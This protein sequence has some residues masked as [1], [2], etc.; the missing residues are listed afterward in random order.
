MTD[1]ISAQHSR[2]VG[3]VLFDGFEL[4]DAFGPVEI[5]SVLPKHF[6]L[7]F[8]STNARTV[9]SSQGV[10]VIADTTIA[11]AEPVD[12]LIVPGGIG[13]ERLVAD[14]RAL[15]ALRALAETAEIMASVC[16]GTAALAIAGILDGRAATSN[17]KAFDWVRSFGPNV[18]WKPRARWVTDAK[19]WTASGVAAGM[20]MTAALIRHLH[21]DET[22]Q[23]ATE[24]I[25]LEVRTD[26]HDDPFA[27]VSPQM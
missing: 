10:C 16:T 20:D 17:K 22:A 6:R 11:D 15:G 21:G 4:L 9:Q 19:F 12:I 3:I 26:P 18:D 13:I 8:I 27:I 14:Q 24:M 25:E 2:T 5:L 23:Y 7:S 1:V